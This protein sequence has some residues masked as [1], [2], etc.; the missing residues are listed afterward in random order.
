MYPT[1][2]DFLKDI[3]GI[4]IPLPIQTYGFLFATALI[5]ATI[6]FAREFKRKEKEGLLPKFY[7]PEKVGYPAEP[8][9]LLTT[10]FLMFFLGFKGVYALTHYSDFVASPQ[11]T[12]ISWDGNFVAGI[13]IA[14]GSVV[15][16]WWSKNKDLLKEPYIKRNETLPHDIVGNML[17]FVGIWGIIGAKVFDAVQPQNLSEFSFKSLFSFSGLTFYGGLLSGFAAGIYYVRKHNINILHSVDAVAPAAA[18]GY[19]VGRLGCHFSGDGCWG[20]LNPDPKPDWLTVV[21]N[22]AWSFD[23]TNPVA[24]PPGGLVFPTSV[25]ESAMMFVAFIILWSLRKHIKIPGFIFA[26]YLIFA[27]I[28]RFLIEFIRV[29]EPYAIGLTQAQVISLIMMLGGIVLIGLMIA[30]K[31][32][33]VELGKTKLKEIN[34][35]EPE[36]IKD[37]DIVKKKKWF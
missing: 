7:L 32:K 31:A 29:T 27:G 6:I 1:I 18:I 13:V 17:I 8:K 24:E 28:E 26:L 22:W 21:P 23:Y 30:K 20:R 15:Y 9:Q 2:S 35:P 12:I 19:A 16:L 11:E 5:T 37:K 33:F 4:N 36:I 25:Y 3:F 14:I 10:F 34:N